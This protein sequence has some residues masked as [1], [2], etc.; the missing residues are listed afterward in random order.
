MGVVQAIVA[1]AKS[2]IAALV[3]KVEFPIA[4]GGGLRRDL[5][6]A[7]GKLADLELVGGGNGPAI[8][9]ETVERDAVGRHARRGRRTAAPAARMS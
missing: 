3:G 9:K 2:V 5:I 4:G 7:G 1:L 8:E 6:H